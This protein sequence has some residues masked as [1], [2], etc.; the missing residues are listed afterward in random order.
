[1]N[2]GSQLVTSQ[3]V[4]DRN[5]DF[6]FGP[7]PKPKMFKNFG[8]ILSIMKLITVTAAVELQV[9]LPEKRFLDLES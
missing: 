8:L 5:Q 7:I 9:Q 1:M 6:G 4:H 3:L 2:V